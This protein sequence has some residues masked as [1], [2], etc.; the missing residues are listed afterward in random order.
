MMFLIALNCL[1]SE[2]IQ[3]EI[4][5]SNDDQWLVS[6]SLPRSVK[7]VYFQRE[8]KID[9]KKWQFT[10]SNFEI[11]NDSENRQL[12]HSI[13]GEPFNQFSLKV[14][15]DFTKPL[16]DYALNV[17]YD[18]G[19]VLLYT[20]HLYIGL[21]QLDLLAH[22]VVLIPNQDEQVIF[23]GQL[24]EHLY[25]FEDVELA[26]NYIYFGRSK[27]I[28]SENMRIILDEELPQWIQEKVQQ[29]LPKLFDFYT[30]EFQLPLDLKPNVFFSY[31]LSND[32]GTWYSG[33]VLPGQIQLSI[34]GNGWLQKTPEN[35]KKLLHFFSHEAA[36][37]WNYQSINFDSKDYSSWIHEGSAEAFALNTLLKLEIITKAEWQ[38]AH[39]TNLNNCI[40]TIDNLRIPNIKGT[41]QYELNYTCGAAITLLIDKALN[42]ANQKKDLFNLWAELLKA[43]KQKEIKLSDTYYI[44]GVLKLSKNQKFTN[45]LQALLSAF[46]PDTD[47]KFKKLFSDLD[48]PLT[49]INYHTN[50]S[51]NNLN[52]VIAH[53]MTLDCGTYSFQQFDQ[54]YGVGSHLKC[55]SLTPDMKIY[56]IVGMSIKNQGNKIHEVVSELCA[57]SK[58]VKIN[59]LLGRELTVTCTKPLPASDP[60][61][62]F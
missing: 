5:H 29:T 31:K 36:H 19:G 37:L 16:D 42:Q 39:E 22:E 43:L 10:H 58:E 15:T 50:Q 38:L 28:E 53:L 34:S 60:W 54:Y 57:N 17:G 13:D 59:S 30:H 18:D 47:E 1:A 40:Q 48:S 4:A 7:Q 55:K 26:G 21:N 2:S 3:L 9:R 44:S 52:Q 14:P 24:N 56:S 45:E 6:Y 20:G 8:G 35:L 61:L 46:F 33:G 41:N 11:I 27:L 12:V 23:N 32:L 49:S 51:Q 25:Q 62:K